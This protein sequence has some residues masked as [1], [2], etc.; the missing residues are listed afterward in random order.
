MESSRRWKM[1]KNGEAHSI[2]MAT[3]T[4]FLRLECGGIPST[5][6]KQRGSVAFYRDGHTYGVPEA[7]ARLRSVNQLEARWM[8]S[9]SMNM[10]TRTVFLRL[11]LTVSSADAR[12]CTME[13]E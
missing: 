10:T 11:S 1:E 12:S 8:D 2:D 9:L 6:S 4:V 5:N 3:P 7:V 13:Q